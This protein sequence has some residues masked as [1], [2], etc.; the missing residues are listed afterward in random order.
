MRDAAKSN[1][2]F[3][4]PGVPIGQRAF[5]GDYTGARRRGL[6]LSVTIAAGSRGRFQSAQAFGKLLHREELIRSRDQIMQT[7]LAYTLLFI[8]SEFFE[9]SPD[10]NHE[11]NVA[12][13]KKP[14][15]CD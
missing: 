8:N 12:R 7:W 13:P 15:K 1:E 6:T 14:Q 2:G 9:C 10:R 11:S 4:C 3:V 5:I